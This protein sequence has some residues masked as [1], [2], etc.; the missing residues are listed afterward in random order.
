MGLRVGFLEA[1]AREL[2]R[3]R[4]TSFFHL[5][6]DAVV[7]KE[8]TNPVRWSAKSLLQR[9]LVRLFDIVGVFKS[10]SAGTRL[11]QSFKKCLVFAETVSDLR[12]TPEQLE[13]DIFLFHFHR[14]QQPSSLLF[15]NSNSIRQQTKMLHRLTFIFLQ[16]SLAA[17]REDLFAGLTSSDC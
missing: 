13:M 14:S 15:Y 7:C 3:E 6:V 11:K 10:S 8:N 17:E 2:Y 4:S 5:R 12:F 16:A 1:Y 9:F